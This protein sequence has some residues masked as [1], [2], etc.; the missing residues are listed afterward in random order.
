MLFNKNFCK[1]LFQDKGKSSHSSPFFQAFIPQ[2]EV[3]LSFGYNQNKP[4]DIL[5]FENDIKF[6]DELLKHLQMGK[7][8]DQ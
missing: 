6:H 4:S 8:K 1:Y 7:K 2:N 5:T 3:P